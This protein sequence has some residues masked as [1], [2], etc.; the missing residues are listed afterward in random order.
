M[1]VLSTR[2]VSVSRGFME[3]Y[4]AGKGMSLL[5]SGFG[6]VAVLFKKGEV[7]LFVT[8]RWFT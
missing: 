1:V 2:T 8:V 3:E 7:R 6:K 4:I 5:L